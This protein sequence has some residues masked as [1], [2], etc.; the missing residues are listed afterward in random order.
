MTKF[1][2]SFIGLALGLFAGTSVSSAQIGVIPGSSAHG[3]EVFRRN[4]CIDC[5]AFGSVGGTTA[6]DLRR[7]NE[8]PRTPIQLAT[9]LW[10]HGPRMWRAQDA[11]GIRPSLDSMDAADLFAY[12]YSLSYFNSPG[13][14]ARG[15]GLFG[16]KGCADCHEIT[17]S[18]VPRNRERRAGP[19]VSTWK[20]VEDPLS[21][22]ED[23]WNHAG[24]VFDE[25]SR[26][27]L[28][29]PQFSSQE[30][31][32]LLAYLRSL[33][34][35]RSQSAVFQ[36]GDPELG[37]VTFER[38]CES[39]HSFDERTTRA[40]I[41]LLQRPGPDAMTGYIAA[42]WNHAP[43]MHSRAQ[44]QFPIFGPG[45]MGNLVAYLFAKRYFYEEGDPGKGSRLF[46]TKSCA[47]CH[48]QRRK[49]VGAPDLTLSTER[50]SPVTISAAIWRHG[51]AMFEVAQREKLPWPQ[52]KPSEMLDLITYLNSRL[53][54]R[55]ARP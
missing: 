20:D 55:V 42:M 39:C 35:A 29:W 26:A 27:G 41:N 22:A 15:A 40:K 21:W 12:F 3:A 4:G 7:S 30:M 43:T 18:S 13:N 45:D 16:T 24:K 33:P 46:Q 52:F 28:G 31:I 10:N 9:A 53:V 19:P 49:Q 1:S 6:P 32:D 5:H 25:R 11:R 47:G 51:P 23:M 14:P 44:A 17:V 38:T 34:E 54:H 8:R 36:P 48:E 2:V 37:R 50:F